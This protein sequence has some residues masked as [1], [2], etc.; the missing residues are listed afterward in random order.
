MELQDVAMSFVEP[1]D[2]DNVIA[3]CDTF[4]PLCKRRIDFEPCVEASFGSLIG[5]LLAT[6]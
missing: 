2:Q 1:R 3:H 4:K 6:N 5:C